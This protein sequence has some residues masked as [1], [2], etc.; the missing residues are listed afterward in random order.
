MTR[1]L[2]NDWGRLTGLQRFFTFCSRAIT[3]IYCVA[4]ITINIRFILPTNGTQL[5]RFFFQNSA[6]ECWCRCRSNSKEHRRSYFSYF[7]RTKHI[8][9]I[10]PTVVP[11][12]YSSLRR[13]VRI[14]HLWYWQGKSKA[15]EKLWF[16]IMFCTGEANTLSPF[17]ASRSTRTGHLGK[18]PISRIKP[19]C[20]SVRE[21]NLSTK[22][23]K[24]ACTLMGGDFVHPGHPSLLDML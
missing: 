5:M 4:T 13:F 3:C 15:K 1:V 18:E 14:C 22:Q 7:I 21:L 24:Q 23:G 2:I 11:I 8:L 19:F 6:K 9:R 12:W 20:E 16:T 10:Q 17:Y